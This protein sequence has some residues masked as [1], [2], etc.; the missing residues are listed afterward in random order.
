MRA[1]PLKYRKPSAPG[2]HGS[3]IR[4]Q[5]CTGACRGSL[6]LL[7]HTAAAQNKGFR[8]SYPPWSPRL[9]LQR[10]IRTFHDEHDA[11]NFHVARAL[12]SAVN[13]QSTS[14]FETSRIVGSQLGPGTRT[15]GFFKALGYLVGW[16]A[17]HGPCKETTTSDTVTFAKHS[18][19]QRHCS[20][21]LR[22]PRG[23]GRRHVLTHSAACACTVYTTT[24]TLHGRHLGLILLTTMKAF[25]HERWSPKQGVVQ[26]DVFVTQAA[27]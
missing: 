22:D 14:S 9:L 26:M 27:Y 16:R 2:H 20:V 23:K 4:V 13:K 18:S 10:A 7:S 6:L 24:H 25:K 8:G 5:D 12:R 15:S 21:L 19:M 11:R 3:F 1:S 17:A